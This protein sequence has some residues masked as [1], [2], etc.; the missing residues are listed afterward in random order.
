MYISSADNYFSNEDER[1]GGNG[2]LIDRNFRFPP[3]ASKLRFV[4]QLSFICRAKFELFNTAHYAKVVGVRCHA[5]SPRNEN[6]NVIY[7]APGHMINRKP[8]MENWYP[9]KIISQHN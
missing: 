7:H 9:P 3:A 8:W 2:D 6:V 1:H 4:I 5:V